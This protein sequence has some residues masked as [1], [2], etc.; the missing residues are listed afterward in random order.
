VRLGH[1]SMPDLPKSDMPADLP[2]FVREAVQM[3]AL[4][5]ET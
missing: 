2:L 1:R 4:D 5:N 3:L